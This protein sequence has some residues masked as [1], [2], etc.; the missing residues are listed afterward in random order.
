MDEKG[1]LPLAVR[2]RS[3]YLEMPGLRLT[4]AQAGRLLGL[5]SAVCARLF[6]HL[7]SSG[8]LRIGRDG[9]YVR[10]DAA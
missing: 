10:A 2:V 4:T 7:V 8:F 9:H 6:A 5:D 1:L 3:E